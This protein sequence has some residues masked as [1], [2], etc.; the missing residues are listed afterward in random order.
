[1]KKNKRALATILVAILLIGTFINDVNIMV[2]AVDYH[3]AADYNRLRKIHQSDMTNAAINSRIEAITNE[4]TAIRPQDRSGTRGLNPFAYDNYGRKVVYGWPHGEFAA[5]QSGT[6]VNFDDGRRG[7]YKYLGYNYD[8]VAVTN[9]LFI[10]PGVGGWLDTK[11]S[12][13]D[14]VWTDVNGAEDTWNIANQRHLYITEY[15]RKIDFED[16]DYSGPG[17]PYP[18]ISLNWIFNNDYNLIKKKAYISL[19]PSVWYR[20]G[21][22]RLE[23]NKSNGDKG[24]N[25]VNYPPMYP[26]TDVSLT[27]T[28]D[29]A[30]TKYV[31]NAED[32]E[33]TINVTLQ[34]EI[35]GKIVNEN[36][37]S[38][39]E[40]FIIQFEHDTQS[41][42]VTGTTYTHSFTKT[43]SRSNLPVGTNQIELKGYA[44][45]KS[46][47]YGES[48]FTAE[49]ITKMITVEVK[50]KTDSY[51]STTLNAKPQSIIYKDTDMK[52]TLTADFA[53]ENFKDTSK[54]AGI[55][56][57]FVGVGTYELPGMLKGSQSVETIIPKSIMNGKDS[58]VKKYEVLV[59]YNMTDGTNKYGAA[60]VIVD[61][62]KGKPP[63][64][65]N[66]PTMRLSTPKQVRAG[67]IFTAWIN[68]SDPDGDQL[69]YD[70][71]YSPA[72]VE[73][74]NPEN[75]GG[76]FWYDKNY[77]GT[78][79]PIF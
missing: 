5:G 78:N 30:Q 73:T 48:V 60:A 32:D 4:E 74:I 2:S 58:A 65:N 59:T 35:T 17:S 52:T 68:A 47:I 66:A 28:I 54:I 50:P 62:S 55:R 43:I 20:S 15:L 10:R 79:M 77:V 69:Y 49:P 63:K 39:L 11:D 14:I 8:G 18:G 46:R 22:V 72:R 61:I 57:N 67:D 42:G 27:M 76:T 51:V 16:A 71:R 56:V 6:M 31:L 36:R 53:L 44:K 25:T 40:K 19:E 21:S 1:M 64:P 29:P 34:G 13:R 23:Y 7:E 75:K 24:W 45:I 70:L 26:D 38:L 3:S 33:L 9:D 37:L 12:Y 41:F